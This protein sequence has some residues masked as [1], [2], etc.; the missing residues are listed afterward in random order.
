MT[1]PSSAVPA[2]DPGWT[3]LVVVLVLAASCF[4]TP[5]LAAFLHL[6]PLAA[7]GCSVNIADRG[8]AVNVEVERAR[9]AVARL[10]SSTMLHCNMYTHL[11][12]V[13]EVGRLVGDETSNNIT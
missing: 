3:R 6:A 9:R 4:M 1:S 11:P 10:G 2:A 7:D 8:A 12:R 13:E 5:G